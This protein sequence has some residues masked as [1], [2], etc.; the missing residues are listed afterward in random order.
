MT[1]P[2]LA[3]AANRRTASDT[4][5][6]PESPM[7]NATRALD[8]A[9]SHDI[10]AAAYRVYAAMVLRMPPDGWY[11]L[12]EI[13]TEVGSTANKVRRLVGELARVGLLRKRN[14]VVRNQN[15]QPSIRYRYA[16]AWEVA[17]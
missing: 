17:V 2:A 6:L 9:L 14:V 3:G 16:L 8:A 5:P 1:V 7:F 13:G 15:G 11:S 12:A 4:L 10:P